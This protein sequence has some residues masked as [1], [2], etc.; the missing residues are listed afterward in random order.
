MDLEARTL[1]RVTLRLVPFLVL[2]YFV[3]YLDRVNVGFAK[4]TM[5]KD[6]GLSETA[7]GL[8]AG[9]FFIAY[10]LFEVP[11][12]L[13]LERFGARKWIARIMFS[14]GLLSGAMAFIGG[15]TSFYVVRVLLGFAEA[16]FF[17]GIIF[18]LT[19]WFPAKERA[20][21]IGLFMAAI[22]LSSVIGAPVSGALLGLDGWMGM[23]GW[24]WLYILEAAPALVLSVVVL[25]YL[26]DKPAD[27]TWLAADEQAWLINRLATEQKVREAAR[28]Y[29]V[30][31]ALTDP[32]VLAV[33]LVYFGAVACNYGFSFFL[34]TIVKGFGLSN[35]QTGFVVAL[36]Y[37]VGTVGMVLWGRRSDLKQERKGHAA[38]ALFIAAAGIGASTM[39]D[40]PLVKMVAFTVAGFGIFASL[41]V[42]WTL[43][44]A[45]LSGP[46]AAGGIAVVNSIGN[47]SGFFGPYAMG[48][49]K[50][51]TGS[52]NGGLWTLAAAGFVAMVIVMALR[53]DSSLEQ[54]PSGR[55]MPAE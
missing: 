52:Y 33:S 22:P 17:P 21:I 10:F 29:S 39:F 28:H 43:P 23:H 48:Y 32:R 45:Y 26:T 5:S 31:Q 50:D 47:L 18:F 40:D 12:N 24:Q 37:I 35:L 14:W 34:P 19:L 54:A 30:W 9:I 27:A 11:S 38:I 7:F 2:C 20:R 8:G 4:L 13:F 55:I 16:G 46:A 25:F 44:T 6:L 41:P 51:A 36:P 15:E 1:R 42:I 49:I 3:A 53:H